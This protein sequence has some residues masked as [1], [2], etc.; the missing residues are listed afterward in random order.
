MTR[1]A[2]EIQDK[3][4]DFSVDQG[5]IDENLRLLVAERMRLHFGRVRMYQRMQERTLTERARCG[6]LE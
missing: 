3:A 1:D 6:M 2:G 5:L 4:R